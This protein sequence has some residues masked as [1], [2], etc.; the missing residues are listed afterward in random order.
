MGIAEPSAAAPE[1]L[2][3]YGA[4]AKAIFVKA[5]GLQAYNEAVRC[6][7]LYCSEQYE[8]TSNNE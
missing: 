1:Q 2:M 8:Q 3:P 6:E 7:D 4:A 5:N